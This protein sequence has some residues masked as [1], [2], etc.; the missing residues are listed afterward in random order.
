[1]RAVGYLF[2]RENDVMAKGFFSF[3][4]SSLLRQKEEDGRVGNTLKAESNILMS[5][6]QQAVCVCNIQ[7]TDG[8]KKTR[9][10]EDVLVPCR[11][12]GRVR[13]KKTQ[14]ETREEIEKDPKPHHQ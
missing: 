7:H 13:V 8:K 2:G 10:K 11:D 4:P 1:M 9:R 6:T 3:F 5:C 12:D 14:H